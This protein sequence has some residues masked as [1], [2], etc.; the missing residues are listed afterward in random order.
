M[1]SLH[2]QHDTKF[3][4]YRSKVMTKRNELAHVRTV[5]DG[6]S[7][8]IFVDGGAELTSD[9]MRAFRSA[10]LEFQDLFDELFRCS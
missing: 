10:L 5:T 8:K 6:F 9:D 2:E 7:R 3:D 1:L 4:E